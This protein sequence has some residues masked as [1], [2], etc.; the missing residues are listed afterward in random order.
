MLKHVSFNRFGRESDIVVLGL[1]PK[2]RHIDSDR[3]NWDESRVLHHQTSTLEV[4]LFYQ[5]L[6]FKLMMTNPF[7]T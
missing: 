6:F 2:F 4:V 7:D 1:I 5:N 3:A